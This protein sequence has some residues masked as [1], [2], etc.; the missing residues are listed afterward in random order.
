M[1]NAKHSSYVSHA[2]YKRAQ[3][4][5]RCSFD[6]PRQCNPA[7]VGINVTLTYLFLLP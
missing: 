2:K 1:L 3:R 7:M 6:S 4:E 5:E